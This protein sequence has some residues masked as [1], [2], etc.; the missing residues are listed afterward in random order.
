M[1]DSVVESPTIDDAPLRPPERAISELRDRL[2]RTPDVSAFCH[3]SPDGDTIGA[4]VAMAL[5]ARQL[6][7]RSEVVSADPIPPAYAHLVGNVDVRLFP[8][9]GPGLAIVCDAATLERIGP[10]ASEC[11]AWFSASTVVNVDHHVTNTGFGHINLVDPNAAASCEVV[12]SVLPEI[13]VAMDRDIASAILAGIVRDS[14]GF[15]TAATTSATLRAA[16]DAVDAGADLETI[17]RLTL[18]ELPLVAIDLW[19]RLIRDLRR[20]AD[21][22]I[23]WTVLTPSL[24]ASAGAEQHD[25][26]GVAEL[27]ARATGVEIGLLLREVDGATRVSIRTA[28]SID[29]AAIASAFGGGGH[30]RRAGCT[31]AALPFEA[32]TPLLDA[33][34]RHLGSR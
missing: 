1:E 17:Y 13:G 31:I 29:A 28:P 10:P 33:C 16:A 34:R 15:S 3:R 9:L 23:A 11:A 32:I 22:R 7:C 21:D 2:R 6:G 12:A 27:I 24:L 30:R 20:E 8:A 25:A 5:A 18:L 19:G 14:H 26:E 4:A